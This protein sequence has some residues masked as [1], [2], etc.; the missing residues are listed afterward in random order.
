MDESPFFEFNVLSF[1]ERDADALRPFTRDGFNA[2]TGPRGSVWS[3]GHHCRLKQLRNP[4][5][6]I[7]F[8]TLKPCLGRV[9]ERVIERLANRHK[10]SSP[11]LGMMT[12]SRQQE[13]APQEPAIVEHAP[14]SR[15]QSTGR[16][17]TPSTP[18]ES[19][20]V[21]RPRKKSTSLPPKP[22]THVFGDQYRCR[23]SLVLCA[24]L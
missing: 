1:T 14:P 24:C 8:G 6:F 23:D 7:E 16:R 5:D 21:V 20:V 11:P 2:A 10:R 22:N 3:K 4:S 9:T 15:K 12:K 13:I 17:L 18:R 19:L